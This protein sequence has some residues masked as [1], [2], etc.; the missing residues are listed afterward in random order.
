[1]ASRLCGCLELQIIFRTKNDWEIFGKS[2]VAV[3]LVTN[4]SHLATVPDDPASLLSLE[5]ALGLP[6]SQ[7]GVGEPQA[8]EEGKEGGWTKDFSVA[9][10]C[11]GS[12]SDSGRGIRRG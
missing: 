11:S 7:A 12:D 9:V 4:A 6:A 1:M 5:A 10:G 2:F 8:G 3:H